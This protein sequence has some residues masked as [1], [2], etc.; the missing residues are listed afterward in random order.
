MEVVI[1]R[2]AAGE[3]TRITTPMWFDPHVHFRLL[4]L[5]NLA[6]PYTGRY[7]WGGLIMPNPQWYEGDPGTLTGEQAVGYRE[8]IESVYGMENFMPYTTIKLTD[9]TTPKII[10][11]A[12]V[13]GVIAAKLM[14]AGVTTNSDV[15]VS[16][17][18]AQRPNFAEM[19]RM[20]MR[21]CIHATKHRKSGTRITLEGERML[22]E[23]FIGEIENI[24]RDFP[25][26]IM[27]VEHV[28]TKAML[29]FV[30]SLPL[31]VRLT[32]TA[33]HPYLTFS[34]VFDA[35]G[36]I[37]D[38][39]K[40]C[41]PVAKGEEDRVALEEGMVSGDPHIMGA[42]DTAPHWEY[43]KRWVNGKAGKPGC[44]TSPIAYSLYL[45]KFV[46]YNC[47]E[48]IVPFTSGFAEEHYGVK[49]PKPRTVTFVKKPLQ[50]PASYDGVVPF[51][52]GEVVDWQ[53]ES[54]T[55]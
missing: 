41:E 25:G 52:A 45:Q 13:M 49:P 47:P 39:H 10:R 44:F 9:Q 31:T 8:E 38:P 29:D 12:S 18:R 11:E 5:L 3:L 32:L 4:E 6:A 46:K 35:E 55:L 26:L 14:L 28:T 36:N 43:L 24:H 19:E 16:D 1:E 53:I 51:M 22:E 54:V 20:K 27:T 34:D 40:Y 17:L 15:A 30:L 50:V 37:L 21:L 48:R 23:G 2:N 42:T 33:H 7:C